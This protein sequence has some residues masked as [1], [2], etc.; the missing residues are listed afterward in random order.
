MTWHDTRAPRSSIGQARISS[1]VRR[2]VTSKTGMRK[3]TSSILPR[4]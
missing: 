2:S 3:F 1:K 4:R